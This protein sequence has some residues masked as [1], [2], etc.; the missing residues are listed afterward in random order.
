MKKS[1]FDCLVIG[2]GIN[3]CGIAADAAGRGLSVALIEQGDFA[4]AT[5][6]ASSKLIHGGLRY[7]EY[8]EFGL[9]RKAL[10]EREILLHI[11]PHLIHPLE[12]IVPYDQHARPAWLIRLGLFVYDYL[13]GKSSMPHSRSVNFE[14]HP[15]GRVLQ[16]QYPRGF[17]YFDAQT[18]DA[19]LVI[20]NALAAAQRGAE[21]YPHTEFMNAIRHADVWEVQVRNTEGVITTLRAKTLINASGPW[22]NH[23]IERLQ[24]KSAHHARL[25]RGS[26]IVIPK[27]YSD[28]FA[29]L[30]QNSD[31]RVIFITPYRENYTMIGTTDIEFTGDPGQVN[32]TTDEIDYLLTAVN[33]YL[34]V[35]IHRNDVVNSWS[36]VRALVEDHPGTPSEMTRDYKIE[37]NTEGP[38]LINVFGGKITTYRQLAE[39]VLTEL[40]PYFPNMGPSWTATTPLPGGDLP[41]A[42]ADFVQDLQ[43]QFSFLAPKTVQRY[44]GAY[45]TRI[46][47]LLDNCRTLDD[48]GICFGADL[49]E[50]EVNFLC[51]HEWASS[52]DDILWR[53]TKLGLE[54]QESEQEQLK[55]WVNRHCEVA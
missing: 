25:I 9:V 27:L 29:F 33:H 36:G 16:G 31:K 18:D 6:S 17:R 37:L 32:T 23:L 21:L 13:G 45:G 12:F 48:L 35:P 38:P 53:R 44:A 26:H 22:I 3:G 54:L 47:Q 14:K 5:S 49:Y 40:Q 52:T 1:E 42:Y 34:Q 41:K 50:R 30:L 43:S 39:T 19:R 28:Y 20:S 10:R 7:L 51:E 24:I 46:H 2:G 55:L 15:A 8:Y 11:A 4:C